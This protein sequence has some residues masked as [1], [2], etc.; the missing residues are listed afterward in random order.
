MTRRLTVIALLAA[1]GLASCDRD[2]APTEKA[3][4]DAGSARAEVS[5]VPDSVGANEAE[6]SAPVSAATALPAGDAI[7]GAP[8]FAV[9]YPG[10]VVETTPLTPVAAGGAGGGIVFTSAASPDDIVD[11]Y[12]RKAEAAGL[13]PV[14]SMNQGETRG[15]GAVGASGGAGLQVVAHPIEPGQTSVQLIWTAGQ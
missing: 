9:V 6:T 5:S 10:G 8:A 14:M 3:E 2:G 1:A 13:A 4:P 11:F 7:D 12:R 15:Y